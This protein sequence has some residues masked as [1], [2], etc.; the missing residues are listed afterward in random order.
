FFGVGFLQVCADGVEI[1]DGLGRSDSRLQMAQRL[2]NGAPVP[3]LVQNILSLYLLLVH[4]RRIQIKREKYRCP[5][6]LR[7]RYTDDGKRML[8]QSDRS[9]HRPGIILKMG[10]P[11]CVAEHDIGCAVG[12][13]LMGGVK[14]AAE[15]GLNAQGVEVVTGGLMDPDAEWFIACAQSGK[16][17]LITCQ[18]IKAVVAIAQV[19]I[20]RIG[21]E[22]DPAAVD[23]PE[24]LLLRQIQRSQ[25][26][27]IQYTKNQ[28][29]GANGQR[30]RGNRCSREP[31]GL[32]QQPKAEACVLVKSRKKLAPNG[33]VNLFFISLA[34]TELDASTALCLG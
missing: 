21:L 30:Q 19:E 4:Q 2:K 9:S 10:V 6:E 25:E 23:S 13:M 17:D 11:K 26:Q 24:A 29:I 8:V 5:A 3:A 33:V 20:V 22:A 16:A 1:G 15:V 14:K 34:A 27:C 18:I 7:R 12:A 31:G 32:A 28:S